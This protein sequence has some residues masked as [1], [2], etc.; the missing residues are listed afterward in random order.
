MTDLGIQDGAS[1]GAYLNREQSFIKREAIGGDLQFVYLTNDDTL[2]T[3]KLL[4]DV[5]NVY[6]RQLP[7]MPKE[8]ICKLVFNKTHRSVAVLKNGQVVIGGITYKTFEDQNFAEIAFC[9]VEGLEQVQGIGTRMMNYC[10]CYARKF[11]R[12]QRFLTYADNNATGYFAKQGFVKRELPQKKKIEFRKCTKAKA[13][14]IQTNGQSPLKFTT[15]S[16]STQPMLASYEWAGFIKEYDGGTLMEC[17]IMSNAP[18]LNCPR[19]VR[20]HRDALEDSIRQQSNSH[21][22]HPGIMFSKHSRKQQRLNPE[23]IPGLKDA[24]WTPDESMTKLELKIG[25]TWE[26]INS[27]NIFKFLERVLKFLKELPDAGPFLK[28]VTVEDAADYFDIIKDPMDLSQIE[29]RLKYKNY[30]LNLEIFKADFNLMLENCRYYNRVDTIYYK[31]ANRL[32]LAFQHYL[33]ENA[34]ES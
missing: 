25:G 18:Y 14:E 15:Q 6:S 1:S 2:H 13:P 24:G 8:Y 26:Q 31:S 28:P 4:T 12:V 19:A 16:N 34:R 7:N 32:E 9:A 10:K 30:Y 21:V 5:K 20:R 33:K 17:E 3:L 22:I 27:E 11:D 29:E 23:D